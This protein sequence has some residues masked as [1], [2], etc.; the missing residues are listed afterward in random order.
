[1]RTYLVVISLFYLF[2]IT[3]GCSSTPLPNPGQQYRQLQSL[4]D[5]LFFFEFDQ[6]GR[7]L[8]PTE[9]NRAIQVLTTPD[10][11][12][13]RILILSFGWHNE[14]SEAVTEYTRYLDQYFKEVT[15]QGL[16]DQLS[17]SK[18]PLGGLAVFCV[19][20]DSK[21]VGFQR[22][23]RDIVPSPMVANAI[24][25]L[26][27]NLLFPLTFWAKASLAD[28][29]GYGGLPDTLEY[30]FD[31]AYRDNVSPPKLYLVG[32]SFGSRILSGLAQTRVGGVP[33]I[34]PFSYLHTI[35]GAVFIQPAMVSLS[36]PSE[37]TYP[38]LV[39]QTRHDHANSFLFPLANVPLNSYTSVGAEWYLQTMSCER[40]PQ[41]S[42]F[43]RFLVDVLRIPLGTLW[44]II[45]TP[46][47]YVW[48][49]GN[50]LVSRHIH[51]I[52]DS[53]AQLPGA[54]V[55]VWAVDKGFFQ[56]RQGWGRYHKGVFDLGG[57]NES[58]GREKT[59]SLFETGLPKIYSPAELFNIQIGVPNPVH[60]DFSESI[61]RS[62]IGGSFESELADFTYAWL[63]P[64]GSHSAFETPNVFK[65]IKFVLTD[66]LKVY[67]WPP[68][69]GA[70]DEFY[71]GR[72]PKG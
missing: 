58:V 51:Y 16:F 71:R 19:A 67:N 52:P 32:H 44:S 26:P 64:I 69:P 66:Q 18:N 1:M 45:A 59:F 61:V 8:N 11:K 15:G 10:S 28:R 6:D 24:S 12:V 62:S 30:I 42:S 49:Q 21:L 22:F 63:D 68:F 60:V 48:A 55:L 29:I 39:T 31:E 27:D 7:L 14:R 2:S 53:L 23:F 17:E 50:Q 4:S 25:W 65:A 9:A 43:H 47:N 72:C 34:K 36:L 38:I 37:P 70:F 20:W 40:R 3:I 35:K 56:G 13:R 33:V 41:Q 46:T 54:E 5:S 57:V